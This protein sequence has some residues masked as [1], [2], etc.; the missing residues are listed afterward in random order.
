MLKMAVAAPMPSASVSTATA[1]KPGCLSNWRK[2]T[3]RSFMALLSGLGNA[4][5]RRKLA[6]GRRSF[7]VNVALM[8]ALEIKVEE[9]GV[10]KLPSGVHLPSQARLAVLVF[11]PSEFKSE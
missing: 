8:K 7:Q 3:L 4:S 10:L 2:A 5:D 11:E 9:D 1:V 6:L